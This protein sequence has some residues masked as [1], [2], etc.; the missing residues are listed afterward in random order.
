MKSDAQ[1]A[2]Q[3]FLG[4]GFVVLPY[5]YKDA[6]TT[7]W[8][9]YELY[10]PNHEI[11]P[12]KT[13]DLTLRTTEISYFFGQ[14]DHHLLKSALDT[15]RLTQRLIERGLDQT[16]IQ[17]LPLLDDLYLG[18]SLAAFEHKHYLKGFDLLRYFW[19]MAEVAPMLD[20]MKHSSENKFS[21]ELLVRFYFDDFC[22]FGFC[23]HEVTGRKNEH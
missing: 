9:D 18:H 2:S 23:A 17:R 3:F 16:N 1:N 5:A 15:M 11:A 12:L 4:L 19:T 20:P 6:G 14:L 22:T 8:G 21:L 10:G 13:F 7:V